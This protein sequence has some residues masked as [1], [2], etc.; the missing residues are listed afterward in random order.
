MFHDELGWYWYYGIQY[1][2]DE[3]YGQTIFCISSGREDTYE[4]ALEACADE[5]RE[6]FTWVI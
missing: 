1:K 4:A 3:F 5:G 6:E 2:V